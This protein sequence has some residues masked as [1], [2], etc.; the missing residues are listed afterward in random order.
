MASRPHSDDLASGEPQVGETAAKDAVTA[1][2]RNTVF[3]SY[4]H[5]DRGWLDKLSAHLSTIRGSIDLWDDTRIGPGDLWRNQ[6]ETALARAKAAVLLVTADFIASEF[7]GNVELPRLLEA[8]ANGGCRVIP[9]IVRPCIFERLPELSRFQPVN[10]PR[11]PLSALSGHKREQVFVELTLTLVDV[12][13]SCPGCSPQPR[14]SALRSV[15][16]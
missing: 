3:I 5:R 13:Q 12:L 10:S 1:H 15:A 9:V 8:A 11:H 7:I 16:R 2:E 6:I 4:S 14:S